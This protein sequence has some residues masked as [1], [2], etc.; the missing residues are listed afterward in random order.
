MGPFV[1]AE[2][3]LANRDE[4]VVCDVR[5]S[6]D[7]HARTDAH[8]DGHVAGAVHV[9]LDA[10]LSATPSAAAGRHPLPTPEAFATT[11]AGLGIAADTSVVAYDDRNGAIA[12]RL[13]WMLRTLGQPAALLD[14]GLAA[15]AQ[16]G[17]ES[18]ARASSPVEVEVQVRP[19]PPELLATADDVAAASVVLDARDRARYRGDSAGPDARAGHI[20]GAVHVPVGENV[21]EVGRLRPLD[22]LHAVYAPLVVDGPPVSSCGSGVTA[23]HDLLVLEHLGLGTGRLYVGSWS[24]WAADPARPITTGDAP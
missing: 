17:G 19:W 20:P 23:C 9:D 10:D 18:A 4:V 21:D 15:W 2:W 5:W 14:G 1:T 6:A 3:L 11:L 24:Q 7:G 22:E 8:P 16:A 13:V 12:A